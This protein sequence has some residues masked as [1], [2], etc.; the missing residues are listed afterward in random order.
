[1]VVRRAGFVSSDGIFGG[2]DIKSEVDAS[3]GK[4]FHALGVVLAVID[5]VHADGVDVE[6]LEPRC[7]DK[8][9]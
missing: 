4:L 1:M 7:L 8:L 6:F 5:G 2:V 3:I 9:S